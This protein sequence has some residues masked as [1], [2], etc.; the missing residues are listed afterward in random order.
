MRTTSGRSP[1]LAR[2]TKLVKP[3]RASK[4]ASVWSPREPAAATPGATGVGAPAV[5]VGTGLGE[6]RGVK[7]AAGVPVGRG[8]AVP[9]TVAVGP[10]LGR[11][12]AEG[13]ADG[14][15]L[16][17]GVGGASSVG[18]GDGVATRV[19]VGTGVELGFVVGTGVAVGFVDGAGVAVG[20]AVADGVALGRG[21]GDGVAADGPG[22]ALGFGDA[23]GAGVGVAVA[24]GVGV[25]FGDG[26]GVGPGVGPCPATNSDNVYVCDAAYPPDDVKRNVTGKLAAGEPPAG[27]VTCQVGCRWSPGATP[28]EALSPAASSSF[29]PTSTDASSAIDT[30]SIVTPVPLASGNNPAVASSRVMNPGSVAL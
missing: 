6:G 27:I 26:E 28:S 18:A 30:I 7:V 21:D 4:Y 14:M 12:L 16:G 2:L 13:V 3:S 5:G 17:R 1:T 9:G 10:T 23:V 24:A 11:G 25:G 15:A 29:E 22:V 19:G 8:V 20:F